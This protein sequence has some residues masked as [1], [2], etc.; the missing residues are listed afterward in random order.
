MAPKWQKKI[1]VLG[2]AAIYW[3]IWK[4]RNKACF[5]GKL[6]N[7]PIEIICHTCALMR[8]QAGLQSYEDKELLIQGVNDMLKIVVQL[9]TK[10]SSSV[11]RMQLLRDADEDED[12][13]QNL[14]V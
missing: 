3:A 8:F 4:T 6:L 14:A 13:E 9:L 11:V 5:D 7:N 2:I 10:P 12:A 1:Y